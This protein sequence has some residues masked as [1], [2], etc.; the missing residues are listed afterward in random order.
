MD[1]RGCAK[2]GCIG[3][4]AV[5]ALVVGIPLLLAVAAR[6]SES[7]PEPR[8]QELSRELPSLPRRGEGGAGT[9][10]GRRAVEALPEGEVPPDR[11]PA[12]G[13]PLAA[14]GAEVPVLAES[15]EPV[16]I[17]LDL[18]KGSF[19][20]EPGPPGTAL[21][22]EADYDASR[23]ELEEHLD[24][25]GRSY[26]LRFDGKRSLLALFRPGRQQESRVR[27]VIPRGYPVALVGEIDM[28]ESR[29]E[30]GGL[31][32]TELDLDLAMGSHSLAFSE[33]LAEPAKRLEVEG[34]MGEL[35]LEGLGNAS[36][37]ELRLESSFGSTRVDLEGAWRNDAE[38]AIEHHFGE[39]V[40]RTPETAAISLEQVEMS[41]GERTIRGLDRL[42]E[43]RPGEPTLHLSVRGRAGELTI[44]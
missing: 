32:L 20:V 6:L 30:L 33:P 42:R 2:G 9:G 43:A 16:W 13:V 12:A 40:V 8:S 34:S 5:V 1:A 10:E 25:E 11:E 3:C 21:R 27:L 22:V 24:P 23:Y 15:A 38:V 17:Y 18:S 29:L 31:W 36:P 35:V 28:G 39:C 19:I 37:G 26:S 14:E 4:L 7:A 41:M 44:E